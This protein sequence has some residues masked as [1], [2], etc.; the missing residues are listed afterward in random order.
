MTKAEFYDLIGKLVRYFPGT[1]QPTQESKEAWFEVVGDLDAPSGGRAV[2]LIAREVEWL[3]PGHN[4]GALIRSRAMP[5]V[6]QATI[7]SHLTYAIFLAKSRDGDPY[8]YLR[9]ISSALLEMA[10]RSDL[11]ARDLSAE[12]QG[13]R[14]RDVARQYQERRENEKRGFSTPAP[15]PSSR[16]IEG[17]GGAVMSEEER[18]RNRIRAKELAERFSGKAVS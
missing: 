4:L 18:E 5:I 1:P 8:G 2:A 12:A 6:T 7:E 13:F 9:P 3:R 15:L 10:E 16:Q 14:V 17:P 11:F